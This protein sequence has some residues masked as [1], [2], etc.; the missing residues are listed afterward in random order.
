M[1]EGNKDLSN[2]KFRIVT[3][4]EGFKLF[5]LTLLNTPENYKE[6]PNLEFLPEEVK[7]AYDLH[8]ETMEFLISEEASVYC[9]SWLEDSECWRFV[10]LLMETTKEIKLLDLGKKYLEDYT[11]IEQLSYC[12]INGIIFSDNNFDNYRKICIFRASKCMKL[13]NEV[14]LSENKGKIQDKYVFDGQDQK[15]LNKHVS[16][17]LITEEFYLINDVLFMIDFD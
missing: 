11:E 3:I 1:E 7:Y 2:N 17:T 4:K 6:N 15:I 13:L 14:K 9:N 12:G 5:H 16:N 8:G 10:S